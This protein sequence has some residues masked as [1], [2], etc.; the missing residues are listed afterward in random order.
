MSDIQK[1]YFAE[2]ESWRGIADRAEARAL[3]A[4]A[5]LAEATKNWLRNNLDDKA[6]NLAMLNRVLKARLSR[7]ERIGMLEEIEDRLRG[8]LREIEAACNTY[9]AS[10]A[11]QLIRNII[12]SV[13]VGEEK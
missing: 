9:A 10:T 8:A 11:I 1:Q 7:F 4:E 3:Q 2:I 12:A 5:E 6:E 13:A